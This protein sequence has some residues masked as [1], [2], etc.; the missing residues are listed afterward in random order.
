MR[1]KDRSA[2]GPDI[3]GAREI[4]LREPTQQKP[5][6]LRVHRDA[7]SAQQPRQLKEVRRDGASA[8]R[9]LPVDAAATLRGRGERL[10]RT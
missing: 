6:A 7:S 10:L 2:R 8:H 9:L 4:D 5:G 3:V 1:H